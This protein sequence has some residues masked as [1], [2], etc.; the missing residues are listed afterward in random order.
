MVTYNYFFK[1][2]FSS[3]LQ[4]YYFIDGEQY[5]N[6]V[7]THLIL[8]EK[9]WISEDYTPASPFLKSELKTH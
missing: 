2:C 5:E 4:C 6:G 7:T 9:V 8:K 1:K 3:L